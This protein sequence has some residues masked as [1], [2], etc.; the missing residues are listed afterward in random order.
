[1]SEEIVLYRGR[2]GSHERGRVEQFYMDRS[3]DFYVANNGSPSTSQEWWGV[4]ERGTVADG[5]GPEAVMRQLA[6]KEHVSVRVDPSLEWV[7]LEALER[8]GTASASMETMDDVIVIA[9]HDDVVNPIVAED[10]EYLLVPTER[11]PKARGQRLRRPA[12]H[13]VHFAPIW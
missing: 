13:A 12:R 3:G 10:V 9:Q 5:P 4:T 11:V 8:A 6:D 7:R 1:M 2:D